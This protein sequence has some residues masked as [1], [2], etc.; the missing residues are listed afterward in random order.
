MLEKGRFPQF[1]RRQS[2]AC[3]FGWEESTHAQKVLKQSGPKYW[4]KQFWQQRIKW[5]NAENKVYW[6]NYGLWT[7]NG[8]SGTR[9]GWFILYINESKGIRSIPTIRSVAASKEAEAGQRN[10][11]I[12]VGL[13]ADTPT[14]GIRS[15]DHGIRP[16]KCCNGT[17]ISLSTVFN[18][19]IGPIENLARWHNLFVAMI[20]Y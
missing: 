19:T 1:H 2:S 9:L 17:I 20:H 8:P 15:N 3:V 12:W 5:Q 13:S 14:N 4:S 18:A 7:K 10:D 11:T 16:K 6:S